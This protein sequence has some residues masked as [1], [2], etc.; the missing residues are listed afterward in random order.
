[1]AALTT[2]ANA[3]VRYDS[4]EALAGVS[5][6]IARAAITVVVGHN[7]SGKSTLLG[8]LAGTTPLTSGSLEWHD[9]DAS[10][11]RIAFVPQHARLPEA[12]P[13]TVGAAVAM[14]RW[15]ERARTGIRLR[16]RAHA[17]GRRSSDAQHVREAIEQLGL[18]PLRG[19]LLGELSGGQ[20][21]R[22]LIAQGIAQDTELLLL[23]EP[24]AGVDA[25]SNE[26]I[27][28]CLAALA[29]RGRTIVVAS[30]DAHEISAAD[31][32]IT[33]RDGRRMGEEPTPSVGLRR[34][35]RH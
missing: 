9:F 4:H 1:M 31:A 33:L 15:A 14:G 29:A 13:M 18:G 16:R 2:L 25:E 28:T 8:V 5:L 20:R 11:G 10:P 26:R 22:T 6:E 30:H 24:T 12:F 23:D 17:D 27:A 21:Q 32:V 35:L 3:T 34:A 7:G 19:R